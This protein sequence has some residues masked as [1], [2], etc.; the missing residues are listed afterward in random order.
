M[1][2]HTT[3]PRA[4]NIQAA[5]AP[6]STAK[7]RLK[8]VGSFFKQNEII[9]LVVVIFLITVAAIINPRF[10]GVDN[11]KT[12]SRDIAILA[13]GAT[14]VGFVILTGG[15]DLSVGS[16]IAVGGVMAGVMIVTFGLPIWLGIIVALLTGLAIG[17]IHGLF[18]TKLKM[19]GFLIT[20]VTMGLARGA[21]LVITKGFPI[22][23]MPSA[24]N[25]FGQGFLFK[26][27]PVPVIIYLVVLAGSYFLLR[28][29]FVG[30]QIYAVGGNSEAARLSG[31]NVDARVILAYILSSVFAVIVG[32]IQAG[33]MT[34]GHPG[35][36][37]GF[38]LAA[39]TACIL[40]GLSFSGGSGNVLG[41]AIGAVLIGILQNGMIM[42][43][44]NPYYH[45][46][47]I[48]L[49]LLVAISFDY[50]RRR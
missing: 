28:F 18:V 22:T 13:I 17:M 36:G 10:I 24:F 7:Q 37:E 23:D 1:T 41:I 11:I 35:A 43:N 33:R 48:G 3:K 46:V 31:V 47:V 19:H 42:L 25:Y 6:V 8:T 32:M 16:L 27:I 49:V 12:M 9:L 29:T 2:A 45:K 40:G 44:I 39:I 26:Q 15:I 50:L 38:E 34:M 20:L 4:K 5:A 14:G 30:R 21:M